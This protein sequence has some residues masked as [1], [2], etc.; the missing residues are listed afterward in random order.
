MYKI[1]RYIAKLKY[2]AT[3]CE[4]L[5]SKKFEEIIAEIFEIKFK[6][7]ALKSMKKN[8][9]MKFKKENFR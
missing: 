6:Y 5:K 8:D 4:L 9:S 7:L 1:K 3:Y 2:T